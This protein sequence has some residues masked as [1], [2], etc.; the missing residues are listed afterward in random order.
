VHW[1]TTL[2]GFGIGTS[3]EYLRGRG[4]ALT[5]ATEAIRWI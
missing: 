3:V 5:E 1:C 4:E 2:V